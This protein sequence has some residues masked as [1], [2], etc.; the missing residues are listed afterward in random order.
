MKTPARVYAV[1][2]SLSG[3]RTMK[4]PLPWMATLVASLE[5]SMGPWLN[6]GEIEP[7]A[8]PRPICI[9][10]WLVP[11]TVW[12][13][14][15]AKLTTL[16][17]KPTVLM[18]ARLFPMTLRYVEFAVRPASPDENDPTAIYT[19]PVV[20]CVESV[21]ESDVDCACCES[22]IRRASS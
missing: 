10:F 2:P 4:K 3:L 14:R 8:T 19:P 18:F 21:V 17:L 5:F 11:P 7:V 22:A 6:T 1:P 9:G 16:D 20:V 13:T 15:S 12:L